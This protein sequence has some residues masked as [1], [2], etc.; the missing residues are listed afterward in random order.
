VLIAQVVGGGTNRWEILCAEGA[1][2]MIFSW[3][4]VCSSTQESAGSGKTACA[5][6]PVDANTRNHEIPTT[7]LIPVR[8]A[9]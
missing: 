8:N 6:R 1:E 7:F 3:G 9:G 4:F 2:T 5:G